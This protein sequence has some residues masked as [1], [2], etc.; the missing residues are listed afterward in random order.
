M[1][2]AVISLG[3]PGTYTFA[4]D[5][6]FVTVTRTDEA[7]HDIRIAPVFEHDVSWQLGWHDFWGENEVDSNTAPLRYLINTPN[8]ELRIIL[9]EAKSSFSISPTQTGSQ[10]LK[11]TYWPIRIP[12][13]CGL[14]GMIIF[15][16]PNNLGFSF[17]FDK[18]RE[19]TSVEVS[20]VDPTNEFRKLNNYGIPATI[21]LKLF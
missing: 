16:P 6:G 11:T 8:I 12:V 7:G 1:S 20:L 17:V 19:V 5:S 9:L 15:E 4:E 10:L 2:A 14:G 3:V 21:Q 18:P 13:T